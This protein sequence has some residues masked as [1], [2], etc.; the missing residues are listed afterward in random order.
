MSRY[1]VSDAFR[2]NNLLLDRFPSPEE[3]EGQKRVLVYPITNG[4][5]ARN[6]A[7]MLVVVVEWSGVFAR[8]EF[9]KRMGLDVADHNYVKKTSFSVTDMTLIAETIDGFFSGK[10][11]ITEDDVHRA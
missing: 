4:L 5:R 7:D 6:M 9:I 3:T 11:E 1:L 8:V 10:W 2:L